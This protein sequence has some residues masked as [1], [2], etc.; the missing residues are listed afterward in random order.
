MIFN[1]TFKTPDVVDDA[2]LEAVK[3]EI[4]EMEVDEE[5]RESIIENRVDK[6]KRLF[7]KYFEYGEY[8]TIQCDTEAET[9]IVI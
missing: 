7:N 9:V 3:D 4:C 5:E 8:V 2:I 6:I 1:V